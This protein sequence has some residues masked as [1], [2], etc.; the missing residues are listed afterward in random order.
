[1][2]GGVGGGGGI[3]GSQSMST[4][5]R[6]IPNKLWRSNSVFTGNLWFISLNIIITIEYFQLVVSGSA[7]I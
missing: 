6:R 3:A 2:C 5:V 1:M 4:V 7:S